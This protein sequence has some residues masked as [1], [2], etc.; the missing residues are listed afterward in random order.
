MKTNQEALSP[1]EVSRLGR[2]WASTWLGK[3]GYAV[4][5]DGVGLPE[6]DLEAEH[7]GVKILVYVKTTVYPAPPKTLSM[8][9]SK[10]FKARAV[11]AGRRAYMA[12][13]IVDAAGELLRDVHWLTL[14]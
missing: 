13:V 4:N 1:A 11:Q 5:L 6:T 9:E 14:P 8:E 3:C 12:G 7:T 10:A 2:K